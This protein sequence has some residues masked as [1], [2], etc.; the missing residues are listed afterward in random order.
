MPNRREGN[1][2]PLTLRQKRLVACSALEFT[3]TE[4]ARHLGIS[5]KTVESHWNSIYK[6]L[7]VFRRPG[8][9]REAM[10]RGE[11]PTDIKELRK[12]AGL[13]EVDDE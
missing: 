7:F 13:D 11:L 6:K 2:R 1:W 10:S 5:P 9:I 4:T 3:D 12:L 8:A